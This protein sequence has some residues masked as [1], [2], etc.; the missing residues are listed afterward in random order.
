VLARIS[1]IVVASPAHSVTQSLR[2]ALERTLGVAIRERAPASA[3]SGIRGIREPSINEIALRTPPPFAT[4]RAPAPRPGPRFIGPRAG[5][6][7]LQPD[8]DRARS[9]DGSLYA[10]AE[11]GDPLGNPRCG[12]STHAAVRPIA[13]GVIEN[14]R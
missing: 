10:S 2:M 14:R 11:G 13:A 6:G 1:S 5:L 9:P 12:C 7:A 4:Q 8:S 3:A